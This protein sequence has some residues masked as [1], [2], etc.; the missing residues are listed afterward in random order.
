MNLKT[1]LIAVGLL[2]AVI[3][4]A[5]A[6]SAQAPV[7]INIEAPRP[8]SCTTSKKKRVTCFFPSEVSAYVNAQA[9]RYTG[10]SGADVYWRAVRVNGEYKVTSTLSVGIQRKIG[11]VTAS[12]AFEQSGNTYDVIVRRCV[13]G[14]E[15]YQQNPYC[16]NP[17]RYVPV[18]VAVRP[19]N[20]DWVTN[21]EVIPD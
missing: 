13:I 18:T 5:G 12:T 17:L 21:F 16:Q 9:V 6:T 15:Q 11:D 4:S 20:K 2:T 7:G 10:G 19:H 8:G 14:Q 1:S 3:G